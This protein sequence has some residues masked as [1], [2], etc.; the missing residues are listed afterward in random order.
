[1]DVSSIF[2]YDFINMT[3]TPNHPL[4]GVGQLISDSWKLFITTWNSSVKTSIL[5]LYVGIAYFLSAL[6]VNINKN[7][8]ILYALIYLVGIITVV[9]ISLRLTMTMLNLEAGKKPLPAN[10]ESKKALL[11]IIPSWWISFLSFFVIAGASLL[12]VIPGIY[13]AMALYFATIILIDQDIH[14]L[15]ALAASRA[16]V[17][18][19]WWPTFGRLLAGS[20]LFG[21]LVFA[22]MGILQSLADAIMKQP[23]LNLSASASFETKIFVAGVEQFLQMAVMAAILP[24]FVGFQ[25]KLYRILQKTR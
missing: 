3:N 13:F 15:Q 25:V 4:T 12:L 19:R 21:L 6:L 20:L 11:F 24:L 22:S 9:W 10:Q 2:Y 18:G 7:F 5:F 16:L 14:G 1:M 17:K 8:F 23:F